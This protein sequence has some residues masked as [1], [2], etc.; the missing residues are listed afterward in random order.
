[1]KKSIVALSA[2]TVAGLASAQSSVRLFGALDAGVS[3]YD[4]KTTNLTTG[5]S[6]KQSSWRQSS[7]G[8]N[9]S[10]LGFLGTEDLGGGLAAGFW[11]EMGLNNDTGDAGQAAGVGSGGSTAGVPNTGPALQKGQFVGVSVPIG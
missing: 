6:T 10:R 3:Y 9:S 11:L 7:S 8:Y 2:L 4:A 1:M 5:A